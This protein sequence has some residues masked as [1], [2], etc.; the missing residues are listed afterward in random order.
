M[1]RSNDLIVGS[2]LIPVTMGVRQG[3]AT[4]GFLFTLYIDNLVNIINTAV[5]ENGFLK[6]LNL[7]LFLDDVVLLSSTKEIQKIQC[8]Y[9]IQF[10]NNYNMK[11][12][13][14]K[15]Y[16]IVINGN[17]SDMLPIQHN[18]LNLI[19]SCKSYIYL[20]CV[21]TSSGLITDAIEQH[22]K[23]KYIQFIKFIGILYRNQNMPFFLKKKILDAAFFSS[24][25]YSAE[26][27]FG[28]NLSKIRTLYM[29]FIKSLLNV[30]QSTRNDLTLLES[31]FVEIEY[32]I[33]NKQQN[34]YK[35]LLNQPHIND[36]DPLSHVLNINKGA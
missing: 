22:V 25:F 30:S 12:N 24:I 17:S 9:L 32:Y 21:F 27:W 35:K 15:S 33:R 8:N 16:F 18:G 2:I 14:D 31:G 26:S 19:T 28:E 6:W 5:P 11:I 3:A 23:N 7:L 29:S 10:C 34:T 20:G 1:Y 4:S 36:H 13:R